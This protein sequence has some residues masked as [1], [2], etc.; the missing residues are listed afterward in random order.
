MTPA[1]WARRCAPAP[2]PT[3]PPW[4]KRTVT[5]ATFVIP[6]WADLLAVGVGALQGALFAGQFRS[7]RLDLLGVAIVGIATGLGGG[8]LRDI[9]ISQVPAALGSNWYVPV[10]IAA[11]LLGMLLERVFSRLNGAITALDALT[12][13]LF[14]AIGTTKALA[15]GLP[16]IPSVFIGLLSAVGGS[17][18]RD[19]LLNTPIAIM[20][21]GSLYAVAAI[22][23]SGTLATL[24]AT[25]VPVFLAALVCVLVTFAVRVLAVLFNWSLP[26]QRRL[27]RIPRIPR[28]RIPRI[29]IPP[30]RR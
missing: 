3:G 26:E 6:L 13:G 7:H 18:L 17:I 15:I 28:P 10:A 25:G 22:L 23:G 12:L 27:E 19:V 30:R 20:Q 9:L 8:I 24:I 4:Y 21:V 11:A 1:V 2:A 14:G 29:H 16:A 5:T